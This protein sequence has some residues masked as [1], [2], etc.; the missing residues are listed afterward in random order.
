MQ[1]RVAGF[2]RVCTYDRAGYG[3]SEPGPLPRTFDRI[4]YERGKALGNAG[5]RG[6]FVL[7]GH[8]YG[9]GVVRR[10]ALADPS[11]VAGLVFVD[12]VS[13]HQ[14]IAM[15]THAGRIGDDAKG[16]AIPAP[17][18]GASRKQATAA[19]DLE[20]AEDSQREWSGEY[21]A[22]WVAASQKGTLGNLPLIVLTRAKGGYRTN[23][24]RPADELERARLDAQRALAGLSTAGTQR[25]VDAGHNMHT[26]VP[27]VVASAIRDLVARVRQ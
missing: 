11:E 4:N 8:W 21:F 14:Y 15:G 9:G 20:S 16:R 6:P 24:D 3:R 19:A 10:H 5:E 23:L 25:I 27:D 7:V 18:D 13:E 22:K 2:A 17:I 26:E 12:I 1:Q